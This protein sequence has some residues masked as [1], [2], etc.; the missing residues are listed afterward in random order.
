[1]ELDAADCAKALPVGRKVAPKA[2]HACLGC[3]PCPPAEIFAAYL[4]GR[5]H[6]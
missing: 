4:L 3:E 6:R 1:M 2:M 5:R